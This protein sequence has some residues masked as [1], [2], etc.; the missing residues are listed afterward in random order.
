MRADRLLSLMMILQT[1]G[2]MTALELARE[3][4][5]SERTIYRDV[6]ALGIAGVPVYAERGPGGGISLL[7]EYRTNLTGLTADEVRALFMLSI[8]TPLL[9]LGVGQELKAAMLKLGAALPEARRGEQMAARQRIHLDA[10]WWGQPASPG[11]H[12]GTVQHALWQDKCLR[13]NTRMFFGSQVEQVVEPL[14]LVA[15]AG[16]WYLVALVGLNTLSGLS[17]RVFKVRDLVSAERLEEGFKR[18]ADFDLAVFWAEHCRQVEADHG[19][20]AVQLRVSAR[21]ARE[22]P[23][24][25]GEQAVGALTQA[26]KPDERG[27]QLVDLVFDSHEQARDKVLSFGGG[28]EVVQPLALRRSVEDFALQILNVYTKSH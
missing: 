2:M 7:E 4:E 1:N 23:W 19:L 24:R 11:Q 22:L 13:I 26:S 8:P 18:P 21:L 15:K 10:S 12:L 14:G 16:E 17:P 6:E 28:A 9:Q 25:L 27:W 5:V 20:F 3:L